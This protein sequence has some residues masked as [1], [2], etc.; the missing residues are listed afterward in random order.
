MSAPPAPA[1]T[2]AAVAA[3]GAAGLALVVAHPPLGWWW[4]AWLVAP[5]LVVALRTA[6]PDHPAD[7]AGVGPGAGRAVVLGLVAGAV[8]YG[9]MLHWI[10][11]AGG[12]VAWVLLAGIQAG[13]VGL[14]ALLVAPRLGSRLLPLH[15]AVLWVGIEWLRTRWPL[16][17]FAWGRLAYSQVELAWLTPT[18]RVLGAS[19]LSLVVVIVGIAA[20]QGLLGLRLDRET[21]PRT[22]LVQL[23]LPVLLVTLVTVGPPP[24]EGALDVLAVQGNDVRHWEAPVPN[25]PLVITRNHRDLTVAAVARDGPPD[26]AVWPESSIDRDPSRAAGA[27]LWELAG[28]A[29]RAAGTLVAGGS[30]DGPDPATQRIVG[31]VVL[32]PEGERDRYVKRMPVPF[33]EF[34]P[35]RA[36]LDWIPALDR[37][38]RDAVRG[39]EATTVEVAPGVT[40]AIAYCFETLFPAVVRSNVMAGTE[41]AGVV[42]TL[43]NDASFRDSGQPEQH[44]AQSRMRAV[45]T[46]RWVVHAA[47]SGVTAVVDPDGRVVARTEPFTLATIRRDVPLAVGTTPYLVLGDLLGG[48]GAAAV[49]GTALGSLPRRRRRRGSRPRRP[50]A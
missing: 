43:T 28:E 49:A 13:W 14:W 38:P 20:L 30:L 41:P 45:E 23:V 37:V 21:P 39:G 12:A 35:A 19:G 46:G 31:A 2:A 33:G 16:D 18:G 3:A 27:P 10:A 8:G 4:A 40:A 9:V 6:G 17:G 22:A 50:A 47:I 7:P 25:A 36:L 44:L 26:V 48:V 15:G 5:L 42:L 32:G 34:V 11:F 1:R 24:T 29:A